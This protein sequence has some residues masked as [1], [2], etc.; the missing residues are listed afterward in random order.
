MFASLDAPRF[1]KVSSILYSASFS[2]G[3]TEIL[4][5]TLSVSS[6]RDDLV[7]FL[8]FP[9]ASGVNESFYLVSSGTFFELFL[10]IL[11]S[12][13]L[14][15]FSEELD[16][17]RLLGLADNSSWI[18]DKLPDSFYYGRFSN[19][20]WIYLA[21]GRTVFFLGIVGLSKICKEALDSI[22]EY[23]IF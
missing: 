23:L 14:L 11:I 20:L 15:S 21:A 19:A 22:W 17:E 13:T 3:L 18:C 16:D 9:Y 1:S 2:S 4:F 6:S 12:S 10:Y 5:H 8:V 7:I